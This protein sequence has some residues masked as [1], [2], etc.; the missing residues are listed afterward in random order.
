MTY[1]DDIGTRVVHT[2][3]VSLW[4]HRKFLLTHMSWLD[5][6]GIWKFCKTPSGN[7][8]FYEMFI[9]LQAI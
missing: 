8:F 5:G 3:Q 2:F 1:F 6:F 7:F 9:I 4:H